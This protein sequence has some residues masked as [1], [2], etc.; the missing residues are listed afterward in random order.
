MPFTPAFT[1]AQNIQAPSTLVVADTSIG[2][3]GNITTRKVYITTANNTYLTAS[4]QSTA[5]AFT[6]WDEP[7]A[8]L[9]LNILDQDYALNIRVDW[10]DVGGNV[11]YSSY[12]LFCF[13]LYSEQFYYTLTQLQ[14]TGNRNINDTNY[15][16]NK[17]QL[18]IY[19]DSAKNAVQYASDIYGSQEQL[20]SAIYM[21]D[22][23]NKFF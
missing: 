18:R 20:N 13:T 3:D 4:G 16:N 14:S 5:I 12:N 9:N 2:T 22:N 15:Y 10:C 8:V 1:C 7:S 6:Q 11:L 19:I 21:I 17:Q 23:Q